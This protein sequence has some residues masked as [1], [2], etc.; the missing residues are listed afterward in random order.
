MGSKSFTNKVVGIFSDRTKVD[1][2]LNEL[3]S[4]G[5]DSGDISVLARD[6][7]DDRIVTHSTTTYPD[8]EYRTGTNYP[9]GSMGTTTSSGS[10]LGSDYGVGDYGVRDRKLDVN[11]EDTDLDET[12]DVAEK[13]PNAMVKGAAAGGA[14][15]LIAGLGLLMVPGL[16]PVLAAGPLA[17]ALTAAAGGAAIG[18]AAGTLLGI[19]KDEGIPSDRADFYTRHF[20]KGDVIVMIHTDEGRSSLARE[21]LVNYNPDTIDTF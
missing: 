2:L 18:T 21:V 15:G 9:T 8:T 6:M 19:L 14:L 5:F 7:D 4:R 16:G 12:H 1:S 3:N 20:N 17:A 13:D 10:V 11:N